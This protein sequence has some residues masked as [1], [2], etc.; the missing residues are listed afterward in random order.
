MQRFWNIFA[1]IMAIPATLLSL[2]MVLLTLYALFSGRVEKLTS[3]WQAY[4]PWTI[5]AACWAWILH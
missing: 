4:I 5:L 1:I 3:G 2:R